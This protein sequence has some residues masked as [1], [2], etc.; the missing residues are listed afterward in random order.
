MSKQVRV[1]TGI[2]V[3]REMQVPGCENLYGGR[4]LVGRRKGSHAAGLVSFP[5]GH[6]DFGETW[7]ECG[8]R[9]KNEE[10]GEKMKIKFRRT[11]DG[12]LDWFVTNDV[13]P[14]YDKHYITIFMVADWIEGEPENMEPEKCDGW[15]WITF[16]ELKQLVTDAQAA[17]WIPIDLI[18]QH[19]LAIGIH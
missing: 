19:R 6:L 10:C 8:E 5:G 12:R 17:Q 3:V 9:E 7:E 11:V 14:Q 4:M 16:S 15:E 1:G 18:E 2:I 13:M